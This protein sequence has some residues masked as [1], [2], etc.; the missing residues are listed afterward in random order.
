MLGSRDG[1][2]LYEWEARSPWREVDIPR[3]PGEGWPVG[4]PPQCLQPSGTWSRA[5]GETT[6]WRWSLLA[7]RLVVLAS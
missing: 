3:E 7:E 6:V 1:H 5:V 2:Q 4:Y